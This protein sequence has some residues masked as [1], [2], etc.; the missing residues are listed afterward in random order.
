MRFHHRLLAVATF[1][2][3]LIAI[4]ANPGDAP[5]K[6]PP[7]AR[8]FEN[9][10][11]LAHAGAILDICLASPTRDSLKPERTQELQGLSARLTKL[12]DSMAA[13]QRDKSLLAIYESTKA[14]MAADAKLKAHTKDNHQNCGDRFTGDMTTYIAG[15]ESAINAV[16]ERSRAA[17]ATKAPAKPK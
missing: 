3:P 7:S 9:V 16:I 14:S 8:I 2:F 11:L 13:H 17:A 10:Y 12:V 4:A 1:A 5:V 15:N 6:Q